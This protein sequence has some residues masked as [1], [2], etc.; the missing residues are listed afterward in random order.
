MT[1]LAW[2]GAAG[3]L[4]ALARYGLALAVQRGTGTAFPWGILTVNTAGCFLFGV[5]FGLAEERGVVRSDLRAVALI[6]FL[7][8]FTT[9]ST[10]AFDTLNLIRAERYAL[11][12]GN[13]LLSNALGVVAAFAGLALS[14]VT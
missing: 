9:F 13:V 11:A 1:N 2:I 10:F 4:G 3:A 14:R 7:G 8:A 6:G 5:V 12:V